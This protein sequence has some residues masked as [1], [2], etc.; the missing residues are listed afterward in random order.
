MKDEVWCNRDGGETTLFSHSMFSELRESL[1]EV[2]SF[3]DLKDRM[4][5][6]LSLGSCK[7]IFDVMTRVTKV[8]FKF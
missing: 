8:C 5:V 7:E 1:K 2:C 3:D 6:Y 4:G